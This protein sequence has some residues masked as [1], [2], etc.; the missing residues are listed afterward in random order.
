MLSSFLDE[1]VML[2]FRSLV[3]LVLD[4]VELHLSI[5]LLYLRLQLLTSQVLQSVH[6]HG[7]N[8]FSL[9]HALHDFILLLGVICS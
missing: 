5:L 2:F 3:D 1:I 9:G 7:R 6:L 8:S 4:Q